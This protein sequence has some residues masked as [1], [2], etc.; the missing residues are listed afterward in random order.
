MREISLLVRINKPRW[1]RYDQAT[2]QSGLP[3]LPLPGHRG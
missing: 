1:Q 3:A 2:Y